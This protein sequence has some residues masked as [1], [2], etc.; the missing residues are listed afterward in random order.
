MVWK[1]QLSQLVSVAET[2]PGADEVLPSAPDIPEALNMGAFWR[3]LLRV[4]PRRSRIRA[5]A[6]ETVP[7]RGAVHCER[8]RLT[9][10][11]VEL[12]RACASI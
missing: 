8:V 1:E 11:D 10:E 12:M 6:A 5:C 9:Q 7:R 2:R 3:R 4:K